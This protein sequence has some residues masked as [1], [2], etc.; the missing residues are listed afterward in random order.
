MQNQITSGN[1]V[2]TIKEKL[3]GYGDPVL[4]ATVVQNYND[5]LQMQERFISSKKFTRPS[6]AVKWAKKQLA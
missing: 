2:A 5:G 1:K 4:V 3:D 6:A